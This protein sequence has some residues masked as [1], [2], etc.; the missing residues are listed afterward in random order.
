MLFLFLS[1]LF[2]TLVYVV[3][4]LFEQKEVQLF[5]A[6]VFNYLT[7]ISIGA[8]MIPNWTIALR[9]AKEFPIW[10]IGGCALG[11]F[12]ISVFY[13]MGVSTQR[14]G[15]SVTTIASKMS[16]VLAMILFIL[17][18]NDEHFTLLNSFSLLFAIAGVVLSS[19]KETNSHFDWKKLGWP[20]IVLLG[21]T[22]VDFGIA[23]FAKSPS[24]ENEVAL[25]SWLGFA[26]AALIGS[27]ILATK[28]LLG[29]I[30]IYRR[31]IVGGVILGILNY[32]GIY[33]LIQA[34]NSEIMSESALLPINNLGIIILGSFL[35]ISIFKEKLS[36]INYL[37]ILLS[38]AAIGLLVAAQ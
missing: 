16:L 24:N 28:T 17:I 25:Y 8:F 19:A 4:K 35:A 38:I 3:F 12:F 14:I 2:T 7:A 23:Y 13:L 20:V 1:I 31:D 30:K 9:G 26:V 10:F 36:R 29:K 11:M 34:Y 37:G 5:V 22:V 33:F 18:R 15:V 21:S 6:I 32:L 27:T